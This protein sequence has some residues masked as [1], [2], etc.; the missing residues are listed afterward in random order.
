MAVDFTLQAILATYI[1]NFHGM[2]IGVFQYSLIFLC[3]YVFITYHFNAAKDYCP[4]SHLARFLLTKL[5]NAIPEL[6]A[7]TK[8]ELDYP[9]A[10]GWCIQTEV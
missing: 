2:V 3:Q 6:L 5:C 8:R 4:S 9:L 1:C 7:S 10:G